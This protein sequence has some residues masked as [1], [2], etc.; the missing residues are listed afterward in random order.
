MDQK[1][2]IDIPVDQ[3]KDITCLC[4]EGV[5]T[6]AFILKE[7]PLLYSPT[8]KPELFSHPVG[9]I[10]V[11]CGLFRPLTLVTPKPKLAVVGG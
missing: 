7:I 6:N 1:M 3:L 11:K 8:G 9:F 4:G 10:C 2:T 5:F